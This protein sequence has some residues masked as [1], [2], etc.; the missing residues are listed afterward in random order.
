MAFLG[1]P[2]GGGVGHDAG[3]F[4]GVAPVDVAVL[5]AMPE[6]DGVT[7]GA[8]FEA[9]FGEVDIGIGNDGL[10]AT[11]EGLEHACAYFFKDDGVFQHGAIC[12]AEHFHEPFE[13]GL[14]GVA[15]GYF[16]AQAEED[17]EDG[18]EGMAQAD[19]HAV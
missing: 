16:F 7:N 6:V 4:F 12:A 8:D 14:I 13:W 17:A 9:P 1:E 15:T 10:G 19:H 5:F 3:E 2:L 18:G 11:A